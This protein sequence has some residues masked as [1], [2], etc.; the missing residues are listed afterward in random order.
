MELDRIASRLKGIPP[1]RLIVIGY[2]SVTP[3]YA[4]GT[5]LL[6][7]EGSRTH[8]GR[9]NPPGVAAIYASLTPETAMQEMLAHFR[10]YDIPL[11]AAMPRVFVA[12]R[13]RLTSVLDLTKGEHRQRLRISERRML[14]CDWRKELERGAVSLTQM[15]GQAARE[16]G[17]EAVLA[18]SAE[19][20]GG[21]NIV[22]FPAK[23]RT[24]SEL[25][26]LDP[27]KVVPNI[28]A[29]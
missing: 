4:T 23:L 11:H 28:G 7:G 27:E 2:R 25:A 26:V 16:S 13:F 1:S 24:S 12:I 6:T 3:K 29:L 19:D 18:P 5:D 10:Y 15:V 14:E 8:G 21:R 17:F 9:W 20:K 22:V